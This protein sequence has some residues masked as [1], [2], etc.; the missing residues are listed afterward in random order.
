VTDR[1]TK[2]RESDRPQSA[3]VPTPPRRRVVRKSLGEMAADASETDMSRR[4]GL[5]CP[6]CGCRDIRVKH[7]YPTA[8]NRLRRRRVCRHCGWECS[9]EEYILSQDPPK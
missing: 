3:D 4:S 2:D 8:E 9:S 6:N 1:D 5:T 7:T